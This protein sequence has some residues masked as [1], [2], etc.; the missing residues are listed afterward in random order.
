MLAV[1]FA[2]FL[3]LELHRPRAPPAPRVELVAVDVLHNL[4]LATRSGAEVSDPLKFWAERL[5]EA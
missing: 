5:R 4:N 1:E 3:G 2:R